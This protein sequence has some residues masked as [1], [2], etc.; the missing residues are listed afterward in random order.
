[1]TDAGFVLVGWVLTGVA[2]SGYRLRI[3]QRSRRARRSLADPAPPTR[4]P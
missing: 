1:M 2:V 3:G 4:A